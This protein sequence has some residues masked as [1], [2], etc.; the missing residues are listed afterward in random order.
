MHI[1]PC[2]HA[3]SFA[4]LAERQVG[5]AQQIEQCSRRPLHFERYRLHTR[6][7]LA[8]TAECRY[9]NALAPTK[10][11]HAAVAV[12]KKIHKIVEHADARGP[13]IL[14]DG[15]IISVALVV[16]LS[17]LGKRGKIQ[18]VETVLRFFFPIFGTIGVVSAHITLF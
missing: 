15:R 8:Q 5:I 13:G 14:L 6:E 3:A 17:A 10:N 2:P 7:H 12:V 1:A 9:R 16:E 4:R 11:S 18:L